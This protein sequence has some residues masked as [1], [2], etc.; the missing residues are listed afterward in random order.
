[1]HDPWVAVA[2]VPKTLAGTFTEY[3][4]EDAADAIVIA[5]G[6]SQFA[7]LGANSIRSYGREKH[8][9]F[10]IKYLYNADDADERL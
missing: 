7:E 5:V 2:D 10:E 6:H 1:M 4:I 3:P 9:L 8:V